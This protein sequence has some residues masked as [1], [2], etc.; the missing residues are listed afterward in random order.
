MHRATHH[1]IDF[2]LDGEIIALHEQL[3]LSHVGG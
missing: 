1:R 3:G 2:D